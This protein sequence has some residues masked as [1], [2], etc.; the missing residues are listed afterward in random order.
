[1]L[2]SSFARCIYTAEVLHLG[3]REEEGLGGLTVESR[4]LTSKVQ[5]IE[6]AFNIE[7]RAFSVCMFN[8]TPCLIEHWIG[9]QFRLLSLKQR[10]TTTNQ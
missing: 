7:N 1:M 10:K 9:I 4:R 5:V 2:L 8:T 6:E 3:S